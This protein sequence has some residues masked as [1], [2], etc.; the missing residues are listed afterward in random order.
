MTHSDREFVLLIDDDRT[1]AEGLTLLLEDEG[2][3]TIVCSDVESAE[4]ALLRYPI[5]HVLTDV[6]FTGSFGYEGL[7]FLARIR[8]L[9][10]ESRVVVMTGQMTDS[11][12]SEALGMGAAA[13]LTK[14][15]GALELAAAL[16][17]SHSGAGAYETIQLPA[18]EELLRGGV[19]AS[20]FQPIVHLTGENSTFGYEALLRPRGTW[21]EGGPAPLFDYAARCLRSYDLNLAAA[22]CAIAAAVLL[23]S[24]A[25][26][27]LNVDPSVIDG[28][29]YPSLLRAAAE[30]A[31][32]PLSRVVV[33]ITERTAFAPGGDALKSLDEL[34]ALGV[35]FALDDHGSAYSHLEKIDQIRPEFMKISQAFGTGFEEDPTRMRIVRHIVALAHDFGCAVVLEGIECAATARAA[36]DLGVDLAQGYH[37]GRAL[38]ASRW[39]EARAA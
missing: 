28:G 20:A 14:P 19:L 3:T 22:D 30:R 7:H 27:F 5:T 37:F 23:P 34:R 15:F 35:R 29:E 10:P 38:E 21:A 9:R 12:R 11:L 13:V 25:A 24:D 17:S 32:L 6:Q 39:L 8:T 16:H 18:I 36:Q 1:I 33:E 4:T 26:I 31:A 2:R